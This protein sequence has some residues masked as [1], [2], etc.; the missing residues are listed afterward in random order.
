MPDLFETIDRTERQEESVQKW[1]NNKLKGTLVLPTGFG[2]TRCGLRAISR[3]LK[4]NPTASVIVV[5]PSDPVKVQWIAELAKWGLTADVITI[6][7]ASKTEMSC[8]MLVL[9]EIHKYAAPQAFR[10]FTCIKYKVILGLTATFNRV[11]GRDALIAEHAPI[12]DTVSL[13]EAIQNNWISNYIEY[14]VLIEADDIEKYRKDDREF[15]EHF[16]FFNRDFDLAMR[17]V[18]DWKLRYQLA[19]ERAVDPAK[20]KEINRQI[21]I[22]A[23][24]FQRTMQARKKFI[25]HHPKKIEIANL[26]L[27]HRKDRKCITFSSTVEMADRIKYGKTYSGRDT[28][29]NGRTILEE[30][31]KQESGVLNT[32]ARVDEG[33]D[34]PSISVGIFLGFNSSSTKSRQRLGR[35]IRLSK[36]HKVK[37]VFTLVLRHTQDEIWFDKSVSGRDYITI[38]EKMLIDVLEGREFNPIVNRKS[39]I[40][41]TA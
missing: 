9:D 13:Q 27:E 24:G 31:K 39:S 15:Q 41:F 4:K 10:I 25:Y 18:S 5:V 3:F 23:A 12:V 14:K 17:C 19:K 34:D 37:E 21:M 32:V 40:M 20:V 22:H 8:D 38:D 28:G 2:K 33:L 1:V 26:I 35:I 30:F 36:D 6:G 29:K 11:D 16:S 7:I